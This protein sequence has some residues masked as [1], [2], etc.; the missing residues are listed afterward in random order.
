MSL[1][2]HLGTFLTLMLCYQFG[3]AF[4]FFCCDSPKIILKRVYFVF[5]ARCS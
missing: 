3:E 2:T 5:V 1:I 4:K